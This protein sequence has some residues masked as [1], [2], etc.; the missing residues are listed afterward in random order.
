MPA[1]R[2]ELTEIVTGL[3]MLGFPSLPEAFDAR[4]T[5]MINVSAG[6]WDRLIATLA[7]SQYRRDC[8]AAWNN[9][10]A[11][12]RASSGLRNRRPLRIEWKGQHQTPGYDLIPADLRVDHVFLI[13]CK[14]LSRIL[15]NA[16]PSHLFDRMLADRKGGTGLDWYR[17]ATPE[18]YCW[19]YSAV[20]R[21]LAAE[22]ALPASVEELVKG[23][24]EQLRCRLEGSWPPGLQDAYRTFCVSVSRASAERWQARL[25]SLREKEEML[26]RLLRFA[27]APYFVLG[28][29]NADVLRLRINTPWDWRRDFSLRSFEV[30][31]D[32]EAGQPLVRWSAVVRRLAD[33]RDLPVEGHVEVRWSHGRFYA[34]PEAKVYL[35]TPHAQVPGYA[36][37]D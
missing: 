20:R 25:S 7:D 11:F 13:S 14:Y 24:R 37:L 30:K 19:F 35:D 34:N 27:S 29:Y 21:E 10:L 6:H 1:L 16:S 28:A 18:A 31:A 33:N 26:W 12:L 2:T 8:Q 22:M 32:A 3:G 4:P 17:E 15:F 5:E 23:Q 9:G 36:P